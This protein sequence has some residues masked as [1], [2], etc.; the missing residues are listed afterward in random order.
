V[1]KLRAQTKFHLAVSQVSQT[2]IF[3]KTLVHRAIVAIDS[4]K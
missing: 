2:K 1:T 4:S 3:R